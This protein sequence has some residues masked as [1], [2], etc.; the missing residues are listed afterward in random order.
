MSRKETSIRT[1]SSLRFFTECVNRLHPFILTGLG[2][3]RATQALAS[4]YESKAEQPG[5]EIQRF[6]VVGRKRRRPSRKT[7]KGSGIFFVTEVKRL[8]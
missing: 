8:R 3:T 5:F 4:D 6:T 2:I 7:E 1:V